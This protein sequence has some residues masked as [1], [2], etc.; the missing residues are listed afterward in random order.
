MA[1]NSTGISKRFHSLVS[2]RNARRIID[3]LKLINEIIKE[4]G[5]YSDIENPERRREKEID[6]AVKITGIWRGDIQ[7]IRYVLWMLLAV[8]TLVGGIIV[9][10]WS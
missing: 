4:E 6:L 3:R 8:A 7:T 5:V 9:K 1:K 2:E 10:G